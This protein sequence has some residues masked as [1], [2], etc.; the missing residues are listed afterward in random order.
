MTPKR[1][2]VLAGGTPRL[3]FS[4]SAA[5]GCVPICVTFGMPVSSAVTR[6][7]RSVS[8]IPRLNSSLRIAAGSGA[9]AYLP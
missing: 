1:F 3:I 2:S 8:L 9:R 6:S 5:A 4:V 7:V